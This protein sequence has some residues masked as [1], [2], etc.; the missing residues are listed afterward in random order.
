MRGPATTWWA[1][2]GKTVVFEECGALVAKSQRRLPVLAQPFSLFDTSLLKNTKIA[3][4]NTFLVWESL[5]HTNTATMKGTAHR[6]R[7][8]EEAVQLVS[9]LAGFAA[10]VIA[11]FK[12][13]R[14]K[15]MK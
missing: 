14:I 1:R 6:Y 11:T 9:S 12:A 13:L 7:Q 5:V 2:Q 10:V 4:L 8:L 3:N 15:L